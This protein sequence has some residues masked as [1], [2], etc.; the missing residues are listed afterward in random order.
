MIDPIELHAFADGE[1]SPE[2]EPVV[3]RL[4]VESLAAKT[5][6]DAII[7][8]KT[9]LRERT[10]PVDSRESW[11]ACAVRIH[12]LER[13]RRVE[14]VVSTRLAWGLSGVFFVAILFAGAMHRGATS[15][16]I[17]SA[18][19]AFMMSSVNPGHDSISKTNSQTDLSVAELMKMAQ[20][21]IDPKRMDIR[22]R[23]YGEL[24]G[25]PVNRFTLRDANGDM[26]LLVVPDVMQLEG[27]GEMRPDHSFRMS[28][29][30]SMNCIGWTDG[31]NTL[32]LVGDRPYEDLATAASL[33]GIK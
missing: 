10:T 13:V 9:L 22:S 27:M 32:V 20:I 3:K 19:L 5:E 16:N 11:K 12:E 23:G 26:A 14:R 1:L 29:V 21:S 31:R 17:N 28:H 6:L 2:R 18:D 8:V 4:L 24:D 7:T 15:S 25:R 33:L 30:G